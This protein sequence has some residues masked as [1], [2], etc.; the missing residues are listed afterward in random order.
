M[1]SS[2]ALVELGDRYAALGLTAAA[3]AAFERALAEAGGD[4]P[5]AARRLAELALL[6]GDAV[7]ARAH[8]QT[9]VAKKG[10]PP[11]RLLLGR[12][13]MAAGEL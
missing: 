8:A 3:R 7:A 11:A 10:G 9:A 6:A 13:Q 5:S 4:D 2:A 1:A 12:A